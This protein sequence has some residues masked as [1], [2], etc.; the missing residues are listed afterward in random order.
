MFCV[1][2]VATNTNTIITFNTIKCLFVFVKKAELSFESV[3]KFS[4]WFND[5]FDEMMILPHFCL[6]SFLETRL[7]EQQLAMITNLK[8]DF[9][10]FGAKLSG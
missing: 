9:R 7:A 3:S 1:F 10:A 2:T 4:R 6:M 5:D 8:C